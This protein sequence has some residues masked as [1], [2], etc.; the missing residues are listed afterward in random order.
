MKRYIEFFFNKSFGIMQE[1]FVDDTFKYKK[2]RDTRKY[3][4]VVICDN[5]LFCTSVQNHFV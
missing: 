3:L 5:I 2:R 4:S 1:S